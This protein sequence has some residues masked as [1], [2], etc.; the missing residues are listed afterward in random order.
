MLGYARSQKEMPLKNRFVKFNFT[1]VSVA[2][3]IVFVY[4]PFFQAVYMSLH[5]GRGINMEFVGIN[6]YVRLFSDENF[7]IAL[8]NTVLFVVVYVPITL[9]LAMFLAVLL[10]DPK[11]KFRGIMR[12]AIFLPSV[13][14]PVAYSIL[15]KFIF[16]LDGFANK[17]L[18]NLKIVEEPI[19]WLTSPF[20]SKIIILMAIIWCWTGFYMMFYLS[21]LQNV[22]ENIYD[23]CKIDG[24]SRIQQFFKITVPSLRPVTTFCFLSAVTGGFQ[25]FDE[26]KVI[27]N[28]GPANA[29]ITLAQYSYNLSFVYTPNFGYAS[30]VSIIIFLIVFACS[31][32][33]RRVGKNE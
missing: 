6:N 16:S 7:R 25:L 20:W 24:A 3:V 27:T 21:S 28:G 22:D 8:G 23:A 1:V 10:N 12:T 29:T 9:L 13:T 33:E 2:L 15:F 31:M 14:S 19:Y 4:I 5:G 17:L 32:I 11:L 26:V 30:T 18:L